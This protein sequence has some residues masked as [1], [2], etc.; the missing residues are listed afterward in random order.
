MI[1]E[2]GQVSGGGYGPPV[3]IEFGITME[4]YTRNP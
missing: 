2:F 4:A 1:L 3:R